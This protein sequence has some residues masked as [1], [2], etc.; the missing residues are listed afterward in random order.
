MISVVCPVRNDKEGLKT[1]LDSVLDQSFKD[2]EIIVV[3]GNSNDGTAEFL[4]NYQEKYKEVKMFQDRGENQTSYSGRNIGINNAKGDIIA[5]IDADMWVE[6]DWLEKINE[7]FQSREIRIAGCNVEVVQ[8]D[9][10]FVN[11]YTSQKSFPIKNFVYE[12]DF[13]PTC[14]LVCRSEI[15]KEYGLFDERMV[16]S[17]DYVFT[18]NL[19]RLEGLELTFLEDITIYHPSRGLMSQLKR[20]FRLGRGFV[21]R[22]KFYSRFE[23]DFLSQDP[24]WK[25]IERWK[26]K[27]LLEKVAFTAFYLVELS[28]GLAGRIYEAVR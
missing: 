26:D 1:T 6:K 14:C 25:T 4:S 20:H 18:N 10:G 23:K 2:F 11:F 8:D 19:V 12:Y 5:F 28:F 7:A 3:D 21:Q 15:F 24:P 17:G 27:L 16:S 22:E 9:E 13:V